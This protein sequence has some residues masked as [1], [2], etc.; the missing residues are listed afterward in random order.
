MPLAVIKIL[1]VKVSIKELYNAAPLT[2]KF[3]ISNNVK[4]ST[5]V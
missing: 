3:I 2:F 4:N 5:R 1:D